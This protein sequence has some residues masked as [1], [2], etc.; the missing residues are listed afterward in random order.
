MA[1]VPIDPAE[2]LIVNLDFERLLGF[3]LR[4]GFGQA[5]QALLPLLKLVLLPA[6]EEGLVTTKFEPS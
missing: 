6:A 4:R 2:G 3:F 5:A 1:L